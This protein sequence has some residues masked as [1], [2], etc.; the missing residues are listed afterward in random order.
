MADIL[1]IAGNTR[2]LIANRG[3]L[4]RQMKQAGH[5][6]SALVP[7]YDFMP[8]IETLDIPYRT[9]NLN[10]S[11]I[12]P[13]AAC[14]SRNELARMIRHFNPDK[15]FAY[16]IKPVVLGVPAAQKAGVG[17][18]YSMITGMGY[19]FTGE[20]LKQ[21]ILRRVACRM[22]RK[23]LSG[24]KRIFFQ[25]PDDVSLFREMQIINGNSPVTM[26]NGSGVNMDQFT[27]HPLPD[28]EQPV[29]FLMIAR[30][31]NDKGIIEFVEAAEKLKRV[32]G[33]SIRFQVIGPYDPNLPH[34]VSRH[35]Y[36]QWQQNDAVTFIGHKAD[37]RPWLKQCHVYV[38]PSYREGTPRSVLEAM[39]TGRAVI[40]TDAPGCRETVADGE[41]GFLVPPGQSAPLAEAMEKFMKNPEL[42]GRMSK[43]SYRR[44]LDK[45]DVGKVNKVIMEAMNLQTSSDHDSN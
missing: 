9:I 14:H 27:R 3:D 33:D 37:V 26:T 12:N 25:N 2:S 31:L 30:L 36:E 10:R 1:F 21:Q 16:T 17:E 34:A 43:K 41:N 29:T 7:E 13:L 18:I 23:A 24:C 42:I 39:A 19:L 35:R 15:V 6:V 5:H 22:Y 28:E 44:A 45:Y 4:I 32:Y 20:S 11:S 8:E 40:T 38:L